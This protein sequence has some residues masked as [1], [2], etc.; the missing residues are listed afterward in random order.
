VPKSEMKMTNLDSF[1]GPSGVSKMQ[2]SSTTAKKKYSSPPRTRT[3]NTPGDASNSISITSKTTRKSNFCKILEKFHLIAQQED[4][5]LTICEKGFSKLIFKG[6]FLSRQEFNSVLKFILVCIQ[7]P[8]C[9][10]KVFESLESQFCLKYLLEGIAEAV[11][12]N[13]TEI[14]EQGLIIIQRLT[15]EVTLGSGVKK[16]I[17]EMCKHVKHSLKNNEEGK[18]RFII[19]NLN[20]ILG[21]LE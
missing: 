4:G 6:D 16:D 12:L 7:T 10:K 1:T 14:V 17:L 9:A 13:L 15:A 11:N 3:T 5:R 18:H 2:V 21:N 8:V 20:S 19:I